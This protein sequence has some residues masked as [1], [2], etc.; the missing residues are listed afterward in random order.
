MSTWATFCKPRHAGMLLTSSTR[1]P[2]RPMMISTPAI[3]APTAFAAASVVYPDEATVAQ[4]FFKRPLLATTIADS[5]R[6]TY[7]FVKP[8]SSPPVSRTVKL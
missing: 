7:W 1:G 6:A 3:S 4:Y 8:T 2:L 5:L